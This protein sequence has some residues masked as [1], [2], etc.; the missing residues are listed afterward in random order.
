LVVLEPHVAAAGLIWLWGD[1]DFGKIEPQSIVHTR[2]FGGLKINLKLFQTASVIH[3]R[4]F[5]TPTVGRFIA[6]ISVIHTRAFGL[7]ALHFT[8]FMPSVIH[9]RVLETPN[10]GGAGTFVQTTSILHARAFGSPTL[11]VSTFNQTIFAI[12]VV[13]SRNVTGPKVTRAGDPPDPAGGQRVNAMEWG[14]DSFH[15]SDIEVTTR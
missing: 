9:F 8:L 13:R 7:P 14:I 6:G 15:P 4:A 1:V 10:V 5:G 3:A 12:S 2:V 11:T